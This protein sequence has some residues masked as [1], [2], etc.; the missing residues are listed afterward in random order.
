M[1]L[2]IT[3]PDEKIPGW[4]V[5]KFNGRQAA[6]YNLRSDLMDHLELAGH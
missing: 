1:S 3:Q 2:S 5:A 6:R 4:W